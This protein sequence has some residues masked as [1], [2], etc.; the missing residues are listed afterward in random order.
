MKKRTGIA[1]AVAKVASIDLHQM[2]TKALLA[3]LARLRMCEESLATSDLSPGE[4]AHVAGI[5]F[6]ETPEWSEAFAE[7]REALATREHVPRPA[8][9]SSIKK[10]K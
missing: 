3:R 7:V 2:P 9:R 1:R 8:P 5:L 6:K 10:Q 4:V